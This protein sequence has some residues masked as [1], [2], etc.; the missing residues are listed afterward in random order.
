MALEGAL[1]SHL[2]PMDAGHEYV[3]VT[4]KV[5]FVKCACK[6]WTVEGLGNLL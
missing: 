2:L 5:T 3:G 6:Y 1:H 4:G